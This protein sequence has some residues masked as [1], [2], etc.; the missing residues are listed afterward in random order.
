MS[1]GLAIKAVTYALI[2]L[3]ALTLYALTLT[4]LAKAH[5]TGDSI[6]ELF[7]LAFF[8]LVFCTI[9]ELL[10]GYHQLHR[11]HSITLR[12]QEI[13]SIVENSRA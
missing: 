5:P 1:P 6:E 11:T 3:L 2:G 13:A 10:T 7:P 8:V 4:S 9:F 12:F